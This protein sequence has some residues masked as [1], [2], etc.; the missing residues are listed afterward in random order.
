VV[1][2]VFKVAITVFDSFKLTELLIA[3]IAARSYSGHLPKLSYKAAYFYPTLV[4][5]C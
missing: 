4:F 3:S 1:P 2:N 5:N